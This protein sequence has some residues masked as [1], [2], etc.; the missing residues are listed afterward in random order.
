MQ[1]QRILLVSAGM[2]A[3]HDQCA[4]E[5]ARRFAERG[6]EVRVVDLLAL[7]PLRLGSALR[8][9][10]G[11]MLAH[12]PWLYSA[13][14]RVFMASDS[15]RTGSESTGPQR[16]A[17]SRPLA[18]LGARALAPVVR[19]FAP[20][21]VVSTFHLAGQSVGELRRRGV[22]GAPS[23]VV[24]TEMVAHA[25]W[26]GGG[27]DLYCC[28][29]ESI[30]RRVRT[31][32]GADAIGPGP[33]VDPRFLR[34][35]DA[36]RT[37]LAAGDDDTVL[38]STGSWGIGDVFDTVTALAA[39]PGVRPVALCGRNARLHRRVAAVPGA[40][41]LGWRDDMP[42]LLAGAAVLVDNAGG[43]MCMEALAAG[44]PVVEYRPIAGHGVPVARALVE[45]GLVTAADDAAS[46]VR[47]VDALR[48]PGPRR[49]AQIERGTA[50]F[51]ADPAGEIVRWL[52]RRSG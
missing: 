37:A 23:I 19:G 45:H 43:S 14:Y 46:L 22:T 11:G 44:V 33:L 42:A 40:T 49:S 20:T 28:I 34:D 16:P 52:K 15:L 38:V 7:L 35:P 48:P 8:G 39:A 13:I 30:A 12:A 21:A 18:R 9:F 6:A 17:R 27:A 50:L 1:G 32:T 2:G 51:R 47:A 10:Y 4:R 5:L 25:M 36:R 31:A 3:G 24:V 41:A 26:L 29:S